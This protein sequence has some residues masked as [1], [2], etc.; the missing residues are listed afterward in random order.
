MYPMPLFKYPYTDYS[1]LNL[2]WV[3]ER[4]QE[5]Y[6]IIDSKINDAVN[7]IRTDLNALTVRVDN[8][9][10]LI[11]GLTTR[12]TTAENNIS[13]IE[14]TI[15]AIGGR[16]GDIEDDMRNLTDDVEDLDLNVSSINHTVNTHTSEIADIYSKIAEIDPDSGLMV[17]ASNFDTEEKTITILDDVL[18]FE[19]TG[20]NKS[21]VYYLQ[22]DLIPNTQ[23]GYYP[24]VTMTF[25]PVT[26]KI[27]LP[28]ELTTGDNPL[29]LRGTYATNVNTD[30]ELYINDP[31][32]YHI[33]GKRFIIDGSDENAVIL[34]CVFS[35]HHNASG[36][37]NIF[38]DNNIN[39]IHGIPYHKTVDGYEFGYLYQNSAHV[40]DLGI[41][42]YI[43]CFDKSGNLLYYGLIGDEAQTDYVSIPV[44]TYSI[45]VGINVP[46]YTEKDINTLS[47][48]HT[49][50][51]AGMYKATED[52]YVTDHVVEFVDDN[53]T[54]TNYIASF[55]DIMPLAS[56]DK[57]DMITGKVYRGSYNAYDCNINM[58]LNDLEGDTVYTPS[59]IYKASGYLFANLKYNKVSL[60]I[61]GLDSNNV[62]Y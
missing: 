44:N 47:F 56:V 10:D 19:L 51:G 55:N 18:E 41:N 60:L 32:E 34:M 37:E 39:T 17:D 30:A 20:G 1:I 21:D 57:L 26:D 23:A 54:S 11:S 6:T 12:V 58:T 52:G 7:P 38:N 27:E 35:M 24:R 13:A 25:N 29:I 43:Y 46:T 16:I 53:N 40:S 9:D 62:R 22:P 15:D 33:D 36:Y 45:W 5:M 61:N 8:I 28:S 59:L 42:E 4:I 48:L 49:A 31:L 3:I 50:Y 2:D 14:L